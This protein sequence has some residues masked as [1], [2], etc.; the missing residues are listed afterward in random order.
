MKKRLAEVEGKLSEAD[1]AREKELAAKE[2]ELREQRKI[3][4]RKLAAKNEQ[5]E[6][7]EVAAAQAS[8]AGEALTAVDTLLVTHRFRTAPLAERFRSALH[9]ARHAVHARH[10]TLQVGSAFQRLQTVL[11]AFVQWLGSDEAKDTRRDMVVIKSFAE[12]LERDKA[13]LDAMPMSLEVK[14]VFST[15]RSAWE[16][17]LKILVAT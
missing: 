3:A 2:E 15:L 5:I 8:V 1:K 11:R 17:A 7:L 9:D 14:P 13:T 10:T 16:Y 12:Q 4:D 6:G